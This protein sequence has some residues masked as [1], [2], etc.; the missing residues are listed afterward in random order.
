MEP[1]PI[2]FE[3]GKIKKKNLELMSENQLHVQM[4]LDNKIILFG[5]NHNQFTKSFLYDKKISFT[6]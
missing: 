2:L 6:R 4:D 1:L 5:I 3:L